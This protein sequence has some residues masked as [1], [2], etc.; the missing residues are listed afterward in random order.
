MTLFG[1]ELRYARTDHRLGAS[2]QPVTK[3]QSVVVGLEE[4]VPG[5]HDVARKVTHDEAAGGIEGT[6]LGELGD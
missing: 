2:R 1:C 6:S 5:V 3:V 4:I